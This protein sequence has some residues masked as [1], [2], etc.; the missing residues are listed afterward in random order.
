MPIKNLE[1]ISEAIQRG[2]SHAD[3]KQKFKIGSSTISK[4]QEEIGLDS[5]PGNAPLSGDEIYNQ[6]LS[7]A[8]KKFYSKEFDALISKFQSN[9]HGNNGQENPQIVVLK[10]AF[11]TLK[12]DLK[13]ERADRKHD[14]ELAKN[15]SQFKEV[16]GELNRL[17]QGDN[18]N[19]NSPFIKMLVGLQGQMFE[20]M[21]SGNNGG[22]NQIRELGENIEIIKKLVGSVGGG[23]ASKAEIVADVLA[24]VAKT[25]IGS[26][27]VQK[28]LAGIGS[29]WESDGLASA[30]NSQEKARQMSKAAQNPGNPGNHASGLMNQKP[31]SAGNSNHLISGQNQGDPGQ[32]SAPG[33]PPIA[34]IIPGGAEP[35][36][37]PAPLPP[38]EKK[39]EP[40]SIDEYISLL[41]S[42]PDP[43][44][45][46]PDDS[47]VN[48]S[49]QNFKGSGTPQNFE[50]E[51]AA[52][53]KEMH[54]SK[55]QEIEALK[56]AEDID[57]MN[58][59]EAQRGVSDSMVNLSSQEKPDFRSGK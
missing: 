43:G 18:G 33:V 11:D 6:E 1:S 32:L 14:Q 3:I 53:I 22:S 30:V 58:K 55:A 16:M 2:D 29:K 10:Q 52:K 45:E 26:E 28:A 7:K 46:I 40:G 20:I 41:N 27:G 47:L 49:E 54:S 17:K 24:D 50:Q 51:V 19:S 59:L 12:E 4:I 44:E 21:K 35:G 36:Q 8:Q 25:A 48:I 13:Q 39:F 15:D 9:N 56:F 34:P 31:N 5:L 57:R 37:V 42:T 38:S 23:E